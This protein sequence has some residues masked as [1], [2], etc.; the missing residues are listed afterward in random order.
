[1]I[2]SYRHLSKILVIDI[3][4][5]P[6]IKIFL[7]KKKKKCPINGHVCWEI[8]LFI[9]FGQE[10][11]G[12]ILFV[13][14]PAFRIWIRRSSITV[15]H[16]KSTVGWSLRYSTCPSQRSGSGP[17]YLKPFIYTSFFSRFLKY[18]I[19]VLSL[20]TMI[21]IKFT[22]TACHMV[23]GIDCFVFKILR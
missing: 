19:Q 23:F 9:Y 15:R 12:F 8:G 16:S 7:I 22:A 13:I 6:S 10:R 14:L 20:N 21:R 18:P 5:Y 17:I 2:L 4:W 1:M 3:Q 11:F